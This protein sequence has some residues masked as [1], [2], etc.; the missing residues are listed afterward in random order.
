MEYKWTAM[1][2]T[3][4][5]T[6]M[7]SVNTYIILIALP[8]IF[9]GIHIDPLNSFQYLLWI[10]MGYGLVT[11][12]LLLSFGRLADMYGRVKLFRLG[13]LIFTIGSILLYLTPDKGST[14]ALELIIFRLIQA[15]GSALTLSNGAAI[16]TDAFPASE[17]GKALGIN[18]VA[19]MSGQF[20]GLLL[21]GILATYNWRYVFLIS[22]PFAILGT[23]WSYW[24]MKEIS[25]RASKTSIDIIGNLVFVGGLA[26]LLVG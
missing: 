17:R 8:A 21:G 18:M 26:S 10:L 23:A 3:F 2:N 24:K 14:G 22:V 19:F 20:I 13:F 11:A 16:I 7:A 15:V 12:T 5:A 25:F 9:N 1:S 4:I 6:L